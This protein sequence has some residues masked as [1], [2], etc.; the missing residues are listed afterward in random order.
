MRYSGVIWNISTIVEPSPTMKS[1]IQKRF[2]I[3]IINEIITNISIIM[4]E[5]LN[6]IAV[7]PTPDHLYSLI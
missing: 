6:I 4:I 7:L 2:F 5:V 1:I 3:N